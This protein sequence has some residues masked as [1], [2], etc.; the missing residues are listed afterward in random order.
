ALAKA[1]AAPESKAVLLDANNRA[2]GPPIPIEEAV[3]TGRAFAVQ[4]ALHVLGTDLD[5]LALMAAFV[6]FS[7]D[8]L[9][10][11]ITP[12]IV[13][14]GRPDHRHLFA[15]V[16][17]GELRALLTARAAALGLKLTSSLRPPLTPHRLGW[18]V[19]LLRPAEPADALGALAPPTRRPLHPRVGLLLRE[20]DTQGTYVTT[21][22]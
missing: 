11:G 5:D 2:D 20:G 3:A 14:S 15:A 19:R 17:S 9:A 21:A 10:H 22:G 4:L 18:P 12:V 8:L 16:L 7:A 13:A 6:E 1:V